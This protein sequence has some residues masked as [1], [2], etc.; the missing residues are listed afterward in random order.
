MILF[1]RDLILFVQKLF[2]DQTNVT[3]QPD[4]VELSLDFEG[5]G[6][7]ETLLD[8]VFTAP[9]ATFA[10]QAKAVAVS[11]PRTVVADLVQVDSGVH[12]PV[13][14]T[15]DEVVYLAPTL[16]VGSAIGQPDVFFGWTAA[17]PRLVVRSTARVPGVSVVFDAEP[18][19]ADFVSHLTTAQRPVYECAMCGYRF[20]QGRGEIINGKAYCDEY[21]HAEERRRR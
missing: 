2:D 1:V 3:V 14:S 16:E 7:G 6:M 5:N 20:P 15:N 21:G 18:V 12:A 8:W 19:D 11:L 17:V 9:T 10:A 4:M 13:V